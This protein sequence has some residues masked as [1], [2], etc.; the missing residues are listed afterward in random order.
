[1]HPSLSLEFNLCME[2]SGTISRTY[3]RGNCPRCLKT[4]S[5]DWCS[6]GDTSVWPYSEWAG[7]SE[8]RVGQATNRGIVCFRLQNAAIPCCLHHIMF[9]HLSVWTC[10][11]ELVCNSSVFWCST[12]IFSRWCRWIISMLCSDE[13]CSEFTICRAVLSPA[14]GE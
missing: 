8:V 12:I 13:L 9:M 7:S 3:F 10:I 11:C 2:S 1:M 4:T 6:T 5:S 14:I